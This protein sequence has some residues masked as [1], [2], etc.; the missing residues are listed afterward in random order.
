MKSRS[1]AQAVVQW[2]YHGSPWP[3]PPGSS[4]P[5]ISA[6]RVAGTQ[7]PSRVQ[8]LTPVTP[9]FWEA[10]AGESPEVGSSRPA[11][12]TWRNPV[13]T[14]NTKLAGLALSP[15]LECSREITAHRSL[16]L[17]GIK[18][19]FCHV[20]Q[21]SLELLGSSDSPSLASHS[22][23]DSPASASRVAGITER[24]SRYATQAGVGLLSSSNSPA[25]PSVLNKHLFRGR[26]QWLRPVIP[27]LWEA[28]VGGSQ[29][30]EIETILASMTGS[31]SVT[32]A[33]VQ[34]HNHDPLQPQ[35]L[36]LKQSSHFSLPSGRDHRR[37]PPHL[38]RIFTIFTETGVSLCCQGWSQTPGLKWSF[39]LVA[40]AGVQWHNLSSPHP[41]PPRFK[42]FSC[43]SFP[44][45]WDYR[46][47]PS[48]LAKFVFVV[49]IGFL[50]VG[51]AGLELPTSGDPP[52]LASQNE[53]ITGVSHRTLPEYSFSKAYN[54]LIKIDHKLGHKTSLNKFKE[55]KL[56]KSTQCEDEKDE[57]LYGDPVS[58]NKQ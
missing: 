53:G 14:K 33:G 36:G 10:A 26:A 45:S 49:E 37:A 44:S 38:T 34:W 2:H 20:A 43:L 31:C 46:H 58:L 29:G 55:I 9:A 5:P 32:Q 47:E 18:T 50:H 51:Q 24:G 15:S 12:P 1:V 23:S 17:L 57:D 4:N 39:T 54:T 22:S 3:Q 35:L 48:H 13:S 28:E 40:Q 19:G 25:L 30:Q 27:A 6:S 16:D 42:Q 8:W 41:L 52:T 56:Y 11:R 21:A 7:I